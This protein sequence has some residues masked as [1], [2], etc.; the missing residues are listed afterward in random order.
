[1][2]GVKPDKHPLV[3]PLI[4]SPKIDGIRAMVK[5]GVVFSKTMKPIPNPVIQE[6]FGHLQGFDGELTVGPA[7]PL[8]EADDVYARS[9]GPIMRGYAEEGV[10]FRFNVFDRWDMP[11][12]PFVDRLIHLNNDALTNPTYL[13]SNGARIVRHTSITDQDHLDQVEAEALSCGY[14]GLMLRAPFGRYKYGQSTE[15]EG[16]LLKLKRFEHGEALIM[17]ILEEME[18]TNEAKMS[19]DGSKVRSSSK[20]GKVGKATLGAFKVQDMVSGLTF[21]VGNGKGLTDAMRLWLWHQRRSLPGQILRYRYQAVGTVGAPR[22]PLYDGFRDPIDFNM[23][24]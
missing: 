9:R 13:P 7:F 6:M 15:R 8:N 10:D 24:K 12:V 17:G 3:F 23:P 14:E 16:L 2:R 19:S 22:L 4:A 21:N 20:A 5:D 11:D 1:M 18:N